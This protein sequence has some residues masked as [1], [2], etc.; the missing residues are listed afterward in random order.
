VFHKKKSV[1]K[2]RRTLNGKKKQ[3]GWGIRKRKQK[4]KENVKQENIQFGMMQFL[5][6]N[7]GF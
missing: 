2:K 3:R 1:Q 4:K 5:C 7:L 6:C